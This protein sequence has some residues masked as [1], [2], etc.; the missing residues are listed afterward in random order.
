[1]DAGYTWFDVYVRIWMYVYIFVYTVDSR[2]LDL[3]YL[4]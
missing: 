1:M 2:Y 3:A 4:E